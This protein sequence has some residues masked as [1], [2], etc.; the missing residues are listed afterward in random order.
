[1]VE[2][3]VFAAGKGYWYDNDGRESLQSQERS[4]ERRSILMLTAVLDLISL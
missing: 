2:I 1:M 3:F 4:L